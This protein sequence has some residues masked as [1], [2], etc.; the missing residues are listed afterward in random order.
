MRFIKSDIVSSHRD[1][2]VT[3]THDDQFYCYVQLVKK[4]R[5][6]NGLNE[7]KRSWIPWNDLN[8]TELLKLCVHDIDIKERLEIWDVLHRGLRRETVIDLILKNLTPKDFDENPI[9]SK[10]DALSDFIYEN[11]EYI[12]FQISCDTCCW[13]CNDLK[14]LECVLENKNLLTAE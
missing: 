9:H 6:K 3:A 11:W 1:T 10:R 7:Y 13:E 2:P 14:V 12:F 4:G 5:G 8:E